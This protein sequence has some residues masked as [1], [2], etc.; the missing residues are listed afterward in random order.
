MNNKFK[1]L[2]ENELMET[3]GGVIGIIIAAAGLTLAAYRGLYALGE[4]QGKNDA[5]NNRSHR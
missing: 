1:A 2:S 5:Y 4:A 3:E